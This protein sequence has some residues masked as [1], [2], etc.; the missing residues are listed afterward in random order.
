MKNTK[1]ILTVLLAFVLLFAVAGCGEDTDTSSAANSSSVVSE[2]KKETVTVRLA[3]LKG[4]TGIGAVHL[5]NGSKDNDV[6]VYDATLYADPTAVVAEC[7]KGSVDIAAVPTNSAS[8]IYQKTSGAYQVLCLNTLGTLY[9]MENGNTV[10]DI[11]SLNGKKIYATGQGAVPQYVLEYILAQNGVKCKV[12]YLAEHSELAAQMIAGK[13][14]LAVLPQPFVTQTSLKNKDVRIAL[15]LTEEWNKVASA[16]G[17]NSMLTMGCFVVK[18]EFAEKN[19][20]AVAQFVTD[21]AD[22]VKA[23]N[24]DPV[25]A[26]DAVLAAQIMDSAAAAAKA[27][28]NCNITCISGAEMKTVLSGFLKVLFEQN[29]QSVGEKLPDDAFYYAQ[30]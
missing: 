6:S 10:T 24:G 29:P 9:I 19:P 30:K 3:A 21:F 28:P 5:V 14:K 16:K 20:Q 8:V 1:R 17:D 18:K 15:N 12:E 2:T 7:I 23:V 11:K 25:A 22:S 27:I 13:V 4:P 26:G